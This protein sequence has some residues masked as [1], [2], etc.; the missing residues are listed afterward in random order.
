M[1]MLQNEDIIR[2][3]SELLSENKPDTTVEPVQVDNETT[4]TPTPADR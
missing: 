1:D 3:L 2:E 4:N